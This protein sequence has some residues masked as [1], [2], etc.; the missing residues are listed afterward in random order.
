MLFPPEVVSIPA[1]PIA[2]IHLNIPKKEIRNVMGPGLG[3]LHAALAAQGISATGPWFTHH[4]KID[5]ETFD[6]EIC[7]PVGEPV[8]AT[9]RV[10]PGEVPAMKA[11][12]AIYQGGYE[13]L[14]GAWREFDAWI[15][16]NGLSTGS[17]L[18]ER[19]V[20]QTAPRTELS[21]RLVA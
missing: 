15:G 12:R 11:V 19:Y 7:L 5:A 6:F 20:D 16:S 17:D 2:F 13:G 14:P 1:Q 8:A 10:Q 18:W 4:L 3:E 9:G 21:R